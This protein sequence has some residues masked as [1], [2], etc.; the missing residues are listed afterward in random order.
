MHTNDR[1]IV[2]QKIAFFAEKWPSMPKIVISCSIDPQMMTSF[3]HES[4]RPRWRHVDA[5]STRHVDAYNMR[6][7][8]RG[9]ALVFSRF[10]TGLDLETRTR[11]LV[12]KEILKLTLFKLGFDVQEPMLYKFLQK[13]PGVVVGMSLGGRWVLYG[14]V[15]LL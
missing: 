6:H 9:L 2:F 15:M 11:I 14:F 12:D 8:R 5:V 13:H 3:D 7:G 1:N 10:E 4:I